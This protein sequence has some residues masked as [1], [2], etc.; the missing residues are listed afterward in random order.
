MANPYV[1]RREF[2]RQAERDLK[3]LALY[4]ERKDKAISYYTPAFNK[5]L[6]YYNVYRQ[7]FDTRRFSAFKNFVQ[8][9]YILA[10]IEAD[11]AQKAQTIFGTWPYI[12]FQATSSDDAGSARKNSTLVCAQLDEDSIY[13]KAVQFFLEADIYGTAI[14]RL[15]WTHQDYLA[16]IRVPNDVGGEEWMTGQVTTFDGPNLEVVPF[17]D[18]WP[19]DGKL[20]IR[21]CK[22]VFHRYPMD[23]DDIRAG[24]ASGLYKKGSSKQLEST[25]TANEAESPLSVNRNFY[26]DMFSSEKQRGNKFDKKITCVDMVGDLPDALAQSGLRKTI[27]T[28]AN[29]RVIIREQPFPFHHGRLDMMFFSYS[30][31]MDPR[32]FHGIGKA[33]VGEKMQYLINRYAS[34]KADAIDTAIEPMWLVNELGG[35]DTQNITTRSGKVVKV[36][37]PV[38]EE[39][40]RPFSPDLRG[41]P[42]AQNEQQQLW[43]MMQIATGGIAD[44]SLGAEGPNRETA[45]SA[46]LRSQ[47]SMTRQMLEI[48]LAEKGFLEPMAMAIRAENRQFLK[49]PH[50]VAILGSDAV[51]NPFTGMPLPQEPTVIDHFDVAM[52]YRVRAV[53]STQM[54]G[55]QAQQMNWTNTLGVVGQIPAAQAM[56]NWAAVLAYTFKVNDIPNVKDFFA[57]GGV[58]P[59]VNQ[60]GQEQDPNAAVNQAAQ[61]GGEIPPELQ[62]MF[63]NG[64]E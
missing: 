54:L 60:I 5:F 11:V 62:Q 9:H 50:Q 32:T 6:R 14:G 22:Y 58:V 34:Q 39:N 21:D 52:D 27:L 13:T 44:V 12:E 59:Q 42:L 4:R 41:I 45:T 64:G 2:A 57:Q 29:D 30:P 47:R 23:L 31:L 33:E 26:L 53:G 7:S 46:G 38:T 25:A 8:V 19:E 20:S 61:E 15:G 51:V 63:N 40:I 36:A 28:V 1:A 18:F 35:V 24:E 16:K 48:Q 56:L 37:G 17:E 10:I 3:L 55:K 43:E 49:L